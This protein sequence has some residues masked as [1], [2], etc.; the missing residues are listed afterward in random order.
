MSSPIDLLETFQLSSIIEELSRNFHSQSVV[1]FESL[2]KLPT[3]VS[4]PHTYCFIQS[5]WNET[6][7]NQKALNLRFSSV[8]R[9][10]LLVRLV[11][12]RV[13][14]VNHVLLIVN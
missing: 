13:H 2:L 14:D 9:I 8:G 3:F 5:I 11:G 10:Y 1:I 7:I 6:E 4:T 12:S